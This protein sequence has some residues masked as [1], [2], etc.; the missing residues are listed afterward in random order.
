MYIENNNFFNAKKADFGMEYNTGVQNIGQNSYEENCASIFEND[1]KNNN[2]QTS[3]SN[4]MTESILNAPLENNYTDNKTDKQFEELLNFVQN[5]Q[6]VITQKVNDNNSDKSEEE[7]EDISIKEPALP[8]NIDISGLSDIANT[9]PEPPAFYDL[10]NG[11]IEYTDNFDINSQIEASKQGAL[12]DCWFLA[13]VNSLSY[14]ENGKEIIKDSIINNNDGTYTVNFKGADVA[15]TIPGEALEKARAAKIGDAPS[16]SIY[17]TGDD[18]VLLL[19]IAT[20]AFLTDLENEKIENL[21]QSAPDFLYQEEGNPLNGGFPADIVYLLTGENMEYKNITTP[22]N[23]Y[24]EGDA[25]QSFYD[26]DLEDFYTKFEQNPD[27]SCGTIHIKKDDSQNVVVTDTKGQDCMLTKKG[28]NHSWSVK[29][30]DENTVT[31]VNPWDS[32][33]EVTVDKAVLQEHVL[34]FEYLAV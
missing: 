15:Y 32:N 10:N 6:D 27:N 5:N 17:S 9:K 13:G 19:E 7:T 18:D 3:A 28:E 11:E 26:N 30:V 14:S 12:G 8:D 4:Y 20:E 25:L 34:G 24:L 16:E 2:F 33:N 23:K 1:I 21:P 22:E 31:M 29:S